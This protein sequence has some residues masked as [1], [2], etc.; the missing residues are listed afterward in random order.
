MLNFNRHPP[1]FVTAAAVMALV[2]CVEADKGGGT[3]QLLAFEIIG[4]NGAPVESDADAGVPVV[5]PMV[6]FNAIFDDFLDYS[7]VQDADSGVGL[8]GVATV[9]VTSNAPI[10]LPVSVSTTYTHQGHPK[11]GLLYPKGPSIAVQVAPGLPSSATVAVALDETKLRGKNGKAVVITPGVAT[12]FTFMTSPFSVSREMS[13]DPFAMDAD[14]T[15]SASNVT[16]EDFIAKVSVSGTVDMM[17]ITDLEVEVAAAEGSSTDFVITPKAEMWP[18]GAVITVTVAAD[19]A[20]QFGVQLGA[21]AVI[22]FPIAAAP[23]RR[24]GPPFKKTFA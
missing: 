17:P 19:A 9:A 6:S 18:A 10:M 23:L 15:V 8:P 4:P 2:G 16:A 21:P 13:D 5:S 12:S 1:L 20:D 22:S 24:N 11:F 3:P 14:L 7:L